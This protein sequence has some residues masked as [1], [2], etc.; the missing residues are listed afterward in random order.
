MFLLGAN[1]MLAICM[2]ATALGTRNRSLRLTDSSSIPPS[3]ATQSGRLT[4]SQPITDSTNI[5]DSSASAAALA[6][7]K[8]SLWIP[9]DLSCPRLWCVNRTDNSQS[10]PYR[11]SE[12]LREFDQ[13]NLT[14]NTLLLTP[15]SNEEDNDEE[16]AAKS[17]VSGLP[18]NLP[19]LDTGRWRPI[20]QYLQLQIQL[21]LRVG[22]SSAKSKTCTESFY[23]PAEIG[24]KCLKLLYRIADVHKDVNSKGKRNIIIFLINFTETGTE[25][26]LFIICTHTD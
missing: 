11:V 16:S 18:V 14:S 10:G 4:P 9:N 20:S 22:G 21:Q 12:L 17:H 24:D 26:N 7:K 8:N 6:A 15:L 1:L 23:S 3:T 25:K 19:A 5:D 13:A 2:C